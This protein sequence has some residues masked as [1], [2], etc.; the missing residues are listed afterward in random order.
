[1]LL[2]LSLIVYTL[3]STK[4]CNYAARRRVMTSCRCRSFHPSTKCLSINTR[5]C[6]ATPLW[7]W[8]RAACL[9]PHRGAWRSAVWFT[10]TIMQT[11]NHRWSVS[12]LPA[13]TLA[14]QRARGARAPCLAGLGRGGAPATIVVHGWSARVEAPVDTDDYCFRKNGMRVVSKHFSDWC[15]QAGRNRMNG[16]AKQALTAQKISWM[17]PAGEL[18]DTAPAIRIYRLAGKWQTV[19][20]TLR[21]ITVYLPPHQYLSPSG[22][23]PP[24]PDSR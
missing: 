8:Q 7:C 5:E 4:S 11:V 10:A 9:S 19:P 21:W 15:G 14:G 24:W 1:M 12:R 3:I 20:L 16:A 2:I 23:S 22:V 18:N 6:N 17:A 13:V